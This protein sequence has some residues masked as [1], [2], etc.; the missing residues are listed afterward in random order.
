[1]FRGLL[2]GNAEAVRAAVEM[3]NRWSPGGPQTSGEAQLKAKASPSPPQIVESV[4]CPVPDF[5]RRGIQNQVARLP[6]RQ[7]NRPRLLKPLMLN[8]CPLAYTS[9]IGHGERERP[10]GLAVDARQLWRGFCSCPNGR[11]RFYTVSRTRFDDTLWGS[12]LPGNLGNRHWSQC[13][14]MIPEVA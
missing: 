3:G 10:N 5:S 12:H 8:G 6:D 11:R 4:L 9:E 13:Y 2:T 7:S 14:S 1:M